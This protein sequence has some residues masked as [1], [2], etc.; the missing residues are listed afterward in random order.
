M[1]QRTIF[2]LYCGVFAVGCLVWWPLSH[3]LYPDPY[4][5][6]LGFAPLTTSEYAMAKVI[7]TLSV[8]PVL[9]MALIARDPERNRDF[10]VSLLVLSTLMVGTY[11]YLMATGDFP[12]G[13][14][15]NVS[16]IGV[17]IALLAGLYPWQAA[18]SS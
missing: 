11:I 10:F 5:D 7:G 17:N 16:L 14:W 13:E 15:I 1:T 12:S 18:Q 8:L 3:W 4:H 6:L 2:R 9:G